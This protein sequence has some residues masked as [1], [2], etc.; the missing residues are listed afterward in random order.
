M[1]ERGFLIATTKGGVRP[2]GVRGEPLHSA[3]AQL[4]RI[5]RR[6]LGD[7]AADLLADPQPHPDGDGV[8]W[9]A[10]GQPGVVTPLP[11]HP[12]DRRADVRTEVDRQLVAIEALGQSLSG[13]GEGDDRG[14]VGRSLILAARRPPDSFIYL[15]G[16]QPVIIAWG[17]EPAALPT[18]VQLAA[19]PPP[20]PAP[21]E[22]ASVLAPDQITTMPPV[23]AMAV[24]VPWGRMLALALP[25][26]LL[27]LG[28]VFGLR[29]C[30]PDAGITTLA[31]REPPPRPTP[32]PPPDPTLLLKAS[33]QTEQ[34]AQAALRIELAAI[35]AELRNRIAACP[36]AEPPKPPPQVAV[37]PPPP[38]SATP[39]PPVTPAPQR[40]P[41]P[42]PP[43]PP[44]RAAP[45]DDR[46]RLPAPT[47]NMS[48]MQGC[49]RTDPFFHDR[50]QPSPGVSTYCFDQAGNGQLEWRR[51]R[52]ACRTRASARFEGSAMRIRDSD[53]RCND[54]STW[55]ADQLVCRRGADGV[56]QCSGDAQGQSGRVTWTVNLHKLP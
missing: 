7:A 40:P 53:A 54:G 5:V 11:S 36:S 18:A 1:A 12:P 17:Y 20:P 30:A 47:A 13:A 49:W 38:P 24:G 3:A 29:A 37:Q 32:P 31:T 14:I 6:R 27:L 45:G 55:Y 39:A 52:T 48:F 23:P 42:A 56:A 10:T 28:G 44:P 16:D 4:R 26:L 22:R 34:A 33:L 8:D 9:Y 35:E 51:G 21:L 19:P 25:L 41:A 50:S 46:L 15:A 2:L 43:P